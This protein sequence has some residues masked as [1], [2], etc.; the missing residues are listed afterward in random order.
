[1]VLGLFVDLTIVNDQAHTSG[2]RFSHKETRATMAGIV[3]VF[4]FLNE[5][6]IYM[7]LDLALNLVDLVL[8]GGVRTPSY[9]RPFKLWF[10]FEVHLDQFFARQG[11][12]PH[13]KNLLVFLDELTETRV[14]VRA[15]QFLGNPP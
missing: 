6:S 3:P 13:S 10:E 5:A 8:W 15:L 11:W 1:M 2:A 12:G 4:I 14:K 9:H 7:F